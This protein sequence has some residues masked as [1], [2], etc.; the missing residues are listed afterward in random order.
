MESFMYAP[1]GVLAGGDNGDA[2][3]LSAPHCQ[4]SIATRA[5]R[6]NRVNHRGCALTSQCVDTLP[7]ALLL[8]FSHDKYSHW[9]GGMVVFGLGRI[10]VPDAAAERLSRGYVP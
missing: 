3:S 9:A 7:F 10:R 1:V 8:C 2:A 4:Q 6:G 5:P